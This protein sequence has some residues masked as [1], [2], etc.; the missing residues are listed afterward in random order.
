MVAFFRRPVVT[1][2]TIQRARSNVCV[3]CPF[4]SPIIDQCD[5]CTCFVD[6]KIILATE[7]CPKGHWGQY[8][9]L[10]N[11]GIKSVCKHL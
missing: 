1:P 4:Y 3:V 2:V 5:V 7:S 6:F 11:T 8:F 9:N 10:F